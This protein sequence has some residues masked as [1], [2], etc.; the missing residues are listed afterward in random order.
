MPSRDRPEERL[1]FRGDAGEIVIVFEPRAWP[2]TPTPADFDP[3][4]WG[5]MATPVG[6][7]GRGGAWFVEAPGRSMVLRHYLRG[8]WMARIS[9]NQYLWRG[10]ASARSIAEFRL[11]QSLQARGLPVPPPLAAVAWRGGARYR[12]AILIGRIAGVRSLGELL[13]AGEAPWEA[14]GELISRFHRAGLDHADLNA[15]NLLFDGEGQG[16]MID[17]D[18]GRLRA[19]AAAWQRANLSRLRRSLAKIG[20]ASRAGEVDAGFR[21]LESAWQAAMERGA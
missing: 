15:H 21:R 5:G 9:R 7:G 13:L 10:E 2:Q 1:A 16:W 20:G 14:T 12:A 11:L 4:H 6:T 19:P 17:F 18:R 8:G 3:A